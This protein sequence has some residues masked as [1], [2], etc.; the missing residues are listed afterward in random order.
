LRGV[1]RLERSGRRHTPRGAFGLGWCWLVAGG[2]GAGGAAFT[3]AVLEAEAVA[4]HLQD[5]DVVGEAVEQSAGEPLGA[6]DFGPLGE[7]QVAGHQS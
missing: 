6:E 7:G 4:V 2:S 1:W 3:P 5:V